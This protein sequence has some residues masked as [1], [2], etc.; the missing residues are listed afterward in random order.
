MELTYLTDYGL[1]VLMY[2]GVN[3]DRRIPMREVA[4]AYDIS[5]EHLRKVVHRLACHGYLETTRGRGGGLRLAC[6]PQEIRIGDVVTLMEHSLDIVHC[7]R[8]PCP[9]SGCCALK[10]ALDDARG[11]FLERL[12][13]YTLASLLGT[14]CTVH[15]IRALD[16]VN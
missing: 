16:T 7:E 4:R 3:P 11:A 10:W 13:D 1:R 5:L 2:A 6:P 9:L 12:N 14:H 8:Q 15:R